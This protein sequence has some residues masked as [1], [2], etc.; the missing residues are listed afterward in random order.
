M[1][2]VCSDIHGNYEKYKEMIDT[3][4]L[5]ENDTLFILGDMIDRGKDG[6]KILLDMMYRSNI[7]GLLGNH[8]VV[9][10]AILKKLIEVIDEESVKDFS[11]EFTD[12]MMDW[13]KD[14]G[15]VTLEGFKKLSDEN[16]EA[17]IEYL[18][19]LEMYDEVRVNGKD[20]ILVHAGLHNFSPNRKL[21]D[22]GIDELLWTR[23]DYDKMYFK[24]KI[25]ITGHT[26][27]LAI[28]ENQTTI[29]QNQNNIA[30]DCGCGFGGKLGVLC[31]D[32]ME[33]FYI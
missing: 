6:I 4:N 32:T 2:Y 23:T 13:F 16:K 15:G 10:L 8:E 24:D 19:E 31:L 11:E 25:L 33:E 18:E 28:K 12:S 20:Y 22:Y 21:S 1:I 7:I 14:G 30:I 17:I 3:I 29:Y 27:V 26:P 5:K 9:A